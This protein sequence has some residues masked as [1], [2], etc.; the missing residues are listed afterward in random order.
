LA[1]P[2]PEP[3]RRPRVRTIWIVLAV[4]AAVVIVP[5]LVMSTLE[6]ATIVFGR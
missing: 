4:V 5:I 1:L 3:A 2:E 6:G